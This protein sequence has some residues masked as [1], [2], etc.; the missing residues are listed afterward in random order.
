MADIR[1]FRA[2][3]FDPRRVPLSRA[4]CP[5]YDVI[6]AERA[7]ALRREERNAVH[8]ELPEGGRDKYALAARRWE[9]WLR[10]GW[11]V[12]DDAAAFYVVEERFRAAG[13][14]RA[15]TGFLAALSV[16]PEH[17]RFVIAHEHTLAKPK[18]DRLRLLGAVRANISPIFG[19]LPDPSGAAR[20]ALKRA[21]SGRPLASGRLAGVGYRL[22]AMRDAGATAALAAAARPARLLI[23]DGH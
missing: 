1:P 9:R 5:P 16:K 15:R 19:L 7:A 4:L 10:E 14:L 18:K 21:T 6:D 12:Q 3:R 23:A 8:L 20:R 11:L 2:V 22:W 13:R 17:A